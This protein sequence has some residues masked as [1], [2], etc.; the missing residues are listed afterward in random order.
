MGGIY[1]GLGSNL[2]HPRFGD[3][4]S[5]LRRSLDLLEDRYDVTVF[6]RSG[7]F[8]AAPVPASGQQWFVNGVAEIDTKLS[9]Q[10]L[11][12]VLHKVEAE[13]GRVRTIPNAERVLD[14][15]LVDFRGQV[16]TGRGGPILPHPRCSVRRF[17]LYPLRDVAPCWRHPGTGTD[18]DTLVARLE[19]DQHVHRLGLVV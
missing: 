10:R 11:M 13:F 12:S 17:V 7:W 19:P 9:P 14:L 2:D 16:S 5:I 3:P 18:I 6:K 1:L 8:H 15:D 4:L